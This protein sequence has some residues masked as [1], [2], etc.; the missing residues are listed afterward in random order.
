[1]SLP[2]LVLASTSP[3]RRDLLARLGL[4]F[5]VAA[6]T[7]DEEAVKAE[8]LPVEA[9]T[10]RLARQKAASVPPPSPRSLI[11]GSDQAATIDGEVLGKPG[12]VA[13]AE[14]QLARLA[15][16]EHRLVTAVAVLDPATGQ[17]EE[18]LDVHRLR[19]R[20]LD[21][22][23]IRRYVAQDRPLDCAG[24]YRIE[25]LGISLFDSIEGADFTAIIG[26]PLLSLSRLLRHLG[27]PLP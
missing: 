16:R 20:A 24:A 22:G 3:Y 25:G 11:I 7:C 9:L 6:P 17:F 19:L 8:G 26:L 10:A 27:V 23:A 21:A 4:P 1:M 5:T 14:A 13:A 15:G 12:T 18:A 2:A